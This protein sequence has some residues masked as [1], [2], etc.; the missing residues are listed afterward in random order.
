M[1]KNVLTFGALV[2]V[3][4][5]A[6]ELGTKLGEKLCKKCE[7]FAEGAMERCKSSVNKKEEVIVEENS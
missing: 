1:V 4:A 6:V 3:G 5:I 2:F 7:G